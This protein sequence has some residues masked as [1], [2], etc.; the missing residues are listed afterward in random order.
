MR[1]EG[2]DQFW[3]DQYLVDAT[4]RG[5]GDH[6]YIFVE[7]SQW[8]IRVNQYN[9]NS[10]IEAFEEKT[11]QG[12]VD[13][14]KGI[15]D[16]ATQYFGPV[17]DEIDNDPRIYILVMDIKDGWEEQGDGYIAGY[18]YPLDEYEN[19]EHYGV[20]L[21]GYTQDLLIYS[22][23]IE[24]YYLDCNP[25]NLDD[26]NRVADTMAHEFQ[27]MIHWGQD[28]EEET[29]L[30]EGCAN[31]S[32][33]L[34][35]YDEPFGHIDQF[36]QY[37]N[38]SLTIFGQTLQDYGASTLWITYFSDHFGGSD[39]VSS[40]VANK[41][42]GSEAIDQTLAAFDYQQT[43]DEIFLDWSIA[44]YADLETDMYDGR[45]SHD[46]FV[47]RNYNFGDDDPRYGVNPVY[48][49]TSQVIEIEPYATQYIRFLPDELTQ[50]PIQVDGAYDSD[51]SAKLLVEDYQGNVLE[52]R[53]F[54]IDRANNGAQ[55]VYDLN[56]DQYYTL[57][58]TS[59][60]EEPIT[61]THAK[62]Q[63]ASTEVIAYPNPSFGDIN[64]GYTLINPTTVNLNIYDM[65]GDRVRTLIDPDPMPD[66]QLTWDGK[67]DSGKDVA[68][69]VYFYVFNAGG[70]VETGKVAIVR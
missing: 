14:N 54:R 68:S 24:I 47:M 27:H 12:S 5:I 9:V 19:Q 52:V 57:A 35:G 16:I 34:C 43:F 36:C 15:Y 37:P 65:S 1:G 25:A 8:N 56:P 42:H 61:V 3:L 64:F 31:Y 28:P 48:S 22:N 69:G 40:F 55:T 7:D 13:S 32:M 60:S 26:I 11:P 49:D 6:C 38:T 30:D 29:W 50:L 46:S 20:R 10:L 62:T 59:R 23:E 44:N 2:Y 33:F 66:S 17:P 18:F 53:D 70:T 58:L 51:L 4:C 21:P 41:S 45:Y 39:A 63:M 67:N